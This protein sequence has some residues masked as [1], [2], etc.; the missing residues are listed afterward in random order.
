MPCTQVRVGQVAPG[1]AGAAAVPTR[2]LA[3]H[4][5][6]AHKLALCPQQPACVYSSGEDGEVKL[7]DLRQPPERQ[8]RPLLVCHGRRSWWVSERCRV[9]G[10]CL[11]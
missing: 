9:R 10:R 11:V 6:R 7:L 8:C 3:Q 4:R 5:G 2:R 1:T